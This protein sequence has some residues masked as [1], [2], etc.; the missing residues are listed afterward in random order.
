MA[1]EGLT[2]RI[3]EVNEI[4]GEVDRISQGKDE[5]FNSR[6]TDL[7]QYQIA[8]LKGSSREEL[9]GIAEEVDDIIEKQKKRGMITLIV[10][11][12]W[13]ERLRGK[14]RENVDYDSCHVFR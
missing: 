14:S 6:N 9:R 8:R 2:A 12:Y 10:E 4:E 7:S 5:H 13:A 3:N 1:D 11:G